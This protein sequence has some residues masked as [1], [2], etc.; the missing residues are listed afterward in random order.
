MRLTGLSRRSWAIAAPVLPPCMASGAVHS[1]LHAADLLHRCKIETEKLIERMRWGNFIIIVGDD[2]S[3]G[4][5]Y[6]AAAVRSLFLA[7]S[8]GFGA[9]HEKK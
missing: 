9:L 1:R 7:Y 4:Q 3:F 5:R 6:V 2:Y 8:L